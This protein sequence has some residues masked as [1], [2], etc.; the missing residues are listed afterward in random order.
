ML[1]GKTKL[2]SHWHIDAPGNCWQPD[3]NWSYS[4]ILGPGAYVT[5]K[6]VPSNSGP[7]GI[8]MGPRYAERDSLYHDEVILFV[9]Y[10][11]KISFWLMCCFHIKSKIVLFSSGVLSCMV[12]KRKQARAS[13]VHL[14][15]KVKQTALK[16]LLNDSLILLMLLSCVGLCTRVHAHAE[17]NRL[18]ARLQS[19]EPVRAKQ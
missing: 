2:P 5:A 7:T 10:C 14:T 11:W 13:T 18:R 6:F 17:S 4:L 12:K 3:N 8:T 19:G 9:E 1:G 15:Q 16:S